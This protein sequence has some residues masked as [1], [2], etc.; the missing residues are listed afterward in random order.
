MLTFAPDAIDIAPEKLQAVSGVPTARGYKTPPAGIDLGGNA[1]A[2]APQ[3]GAYI[4]ALDD[5]AATYVGTAAALYRYDSGTW[6]DV[7]R[8]SGYSLGTARWKFA[9]FGNTKFAINKATV[10]QSATGGAF[11][12]VSNAPKAGAMETASGFLLL[13]NTDDAGLGITGGPNADAPHRWWCSQ[14]F[15][16]TGTWAPDITKQCVTGLLVET[17]GGII[18]LKRLNADCVAYKARSIYLGRYIRDSSFVWQWQCYSHDIGCPA[19]DAVVGVGG[20]HY[21]PG[22]NDFYAFNGNGSPVPIGALVKDWFFARLNRSNISLIQALHDPAAKVIY[23]HYPTSGTTLA[24][25]VA[26]HYDTQRWGAFDLTVKDVFPSVTGEI[27]Y[28]NVG[29]Y[30]TSYEDTR[31]AE[32]SYDAAFWRANTPILA[33]IDSSNK[34][35]NLAGTGTALTLTTGWYGDERIVSM[36]VRV[37]PRFRAAASVGTIT[38][39]TAMNLGESTLPGASSSLSSGRFDVMQA[40][41]YHQFDASFT[42]A[43]ELEAVEPTLVPQGEE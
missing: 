9:A 7:S 25:C 23:W 2:A 29:N 32:L 34:L 40:A 41:R 33:Y 42:G 14:I 17:P 24:A 19:A 36:C 4:V 10:L 12:D 28:S 16:P 13:A 6:T 21:F 5:T 37:K 22:E 39:R 27:T 31:L 8:G 1:L 35:M 26:Y 3:G 38:G 43:C 30:F 18:S 15:N 11:A 20:V